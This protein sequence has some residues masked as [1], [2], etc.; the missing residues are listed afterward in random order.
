MKP[1]TSTVI[2]I[3]DSVPATIH[4][5]SVLSVEGDNFVIEIAGI[6]QAAKTM[7]SCLVRPQVGDLIMY[8]QHDSGS[9]YI[10]GIIERPENPDMTVEFPGNTTFKNTAGTLSL[11]ASESVNLVSSGK[12]NCLADQVV[13]KS[14]E[15]TVDYQTIT[16]KGS[17]LQAS[18]DHVKLY[19]QSITTMA[20]QAID[21]F[22]RYIR[23][24]DESDQV[25]AGQMTR[26]VSGMYSMDSKYTIMVSKK[27]T[28]I[29]GQRIHMG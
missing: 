15:A 17:L 21:R 20:R 9:Y 28:K 27:D 4:H 16:A 5:A 14:R 11:M 13:H 24:S 22:K 1:E 10:L 2:P 3:V 25:K 19:S 12:L 29:D 7:F 26:D 23:H 6:P 8:S 18:F